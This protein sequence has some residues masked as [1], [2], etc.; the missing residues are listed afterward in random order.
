M[1]SVWMPDALRKEGAHGGTRG[2]PVPSNA[3][4]EPLR[5]GQ[6][7][8]LLQRVVLDLADALARHAE[9]P[10]D[11][12]ERARLRAREA[13]A[14]LDHLA[15]ALR[16][17]GE[18]VL[19]VLAAQLHLGRV[20]R[21]LGLLVLDEVAELGL[22]LLADRLLQ[23]DRVLGHTQDVADLRRGHLELDCDLVGP[24]L[25]A[26]ALDELALDVHD[27]VQ[28]LDHVH[29]DADRARLVGDR[30]RHGLA[31]PPRRVG[32]E[33]VALA[34][35]ELLDRADQAERA[36]LDQVE[37]AEPAAKVRLRDRHDQA[38]VRLD[39]LRLRAHVAAL[40]PLRQVDLLVGGQQ[41]HLAD[42]TQVEAQRVERG[43]DGQVE[44]RALLLRGQ[45]GLLVGRVLVVLA[46]HQL[47]GVVD[48]VRVEVLD[49]L[50]GELDLFEPGDDLVIGE[51]A[52]LEP[53]LD[54]LVELFD[55]REGNV[56]GE[57]LTSGGLADCPKRTMARTGPLSPSASPRRVGCYTGI[58]GSGNNF[59]TNWR[60]PR[61]AL[62]GCS[63]REPRRIR[64]GRAR[65]APRRRPA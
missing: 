34:V 18:R 41:R 50:L 51:E 14:E 10:T 4:F 65:A 61:R 59:F 1:W 16:Q 6:G 35:V 11:L 25:A 63:P 60:R 44:L 13:E 22:L 33:L 38:E 40:D 9:G 55:V 39:H 7:L 57:H 24:G 36:L 17:R 23:R 64:P 2:S 49:L 26:E 29:R 31:D 27:L 12:L 47:D 42:L 21:R 3:V 52:L 5:L 45:R 48:Q 46:L 62:R 58:P 30:P 53:V 19:D 20:E 56:D 15:V 54:Q 8:E 28:L 37:E 32:R 43:L